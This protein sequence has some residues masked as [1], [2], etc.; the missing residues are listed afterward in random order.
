MGGG[1]DPLCIEGGAP[2]GPADM[3]AAP[4][5][6]NGGG[7]PPG[8]GR[9]PTAKRGQVPV[10]EPVSEAAG[11][12]R[13][14]NAPGGGIGMPGGGGPP[15]PAAHRIVLASWLGVHAEKVALSHRGH[16]ALTL[17]ATKRWRATWTSHHRRWREPLRR[18]TAHRWRTVEPART[19]WTTHHRVHHGRRE[20]GSR[21]TT[22]RTANEAHC[23]FPGPSQ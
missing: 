12:L 17:R 11:T 21:R 23:T 1:G 2:V 6:R 7:I 10:S 20:P 8:G 18:R 9:K 4:G 5:G 16:S 19:A 14:R 13:A 22:H 3:V 15:M